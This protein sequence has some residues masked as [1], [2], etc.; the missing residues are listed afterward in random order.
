[1]R[2]IIEGNIRKVGEK[3]EEVWE[4]FKIMSKNLRQI[5]E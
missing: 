3:C 4:K 5:E 1:M 2:C